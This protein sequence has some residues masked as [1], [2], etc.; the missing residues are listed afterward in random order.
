MKK[1]LAFSALGVM[2]ALGF[3]QAD[4]ARTWTQAQGNKS[5]QG[6]LIKINGDT[7]EIVTNSNKIVKIKQSELSQKDQDWVKEQG[8]KAADKSTIKLKPSANQLNIVYFLGSDR[9]PVEGYEKRLSDLMLYAQQF[10]GKEMLRNGFGPRSFGLSMKSP[11]TVNIIMYKAKGPA[12]DYPYENGG[13]FKASKEVNEYLDANGLRK[14]QHTL[15]IFPTFYDDKNTDMTPG[16]VPFYGLGKTCCAL[17]YKFFDIAHLGEKSPKGNLLTKWY[18]GMIHELGHG[19][20]LPHNH[21]TATDE[22]NLGTALM[23]AGNYT[24][25]L[26]PTFITPA[27]CAILDGCE[28]FSTNPKQEFY[29]QQPQLTVKPLNITCTDKEITIK[30]DYKS[31]TVVKSI[32]VFIEE[33]PFGVNRDYEANTFT[34]KMDSKSKDF[35][36]NIPMSEI[37]GVKGNDFQVRLQFVFE[38]GQLIYK[39]FNFKKDDLKPINE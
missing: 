20:N 12:T 29:K 2:A 16:G 39:P 8:V 37:N 32:N 15:I 10:Y 36:F 25:G 1:I 19:L 13:G 14:S 18:G 7:L 34:A 5:I 35:S 30:G 26:Q 23:G 24:F 27:S 17:D 11:D 3:T 4:E 33:P 21:A 6:K 31:D 38:N 28:V 9:E 22:K